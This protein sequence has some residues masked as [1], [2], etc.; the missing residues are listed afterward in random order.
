[1]EVLQVNIESLKKPNWSQE[2]LRNAELV[3][4]FVQKVMNEHDFSYVMEK[5]S[6]SPYKQHNRGMPNGIKGVVDTIQKLIKSSPAY[7]YDVK[8]I[9]VDGNYVHFHSHV[10]L[11][12]KHRGNP[13]MGLN[14]KDTW[15]IDND[16][17]VEHWDAIQPIHGFMRLYA[18]MT[19]GKVV[20]SNTLF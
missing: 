7:T 9:S 16:K 6:D 19:G 17:I 20:N 11:N 18:W 4:D 1:M 10:T 14:I 2:E 13:E 12:E 15:R 8:D 5:F 3:A